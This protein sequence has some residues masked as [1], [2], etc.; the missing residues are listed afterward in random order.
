MRSVDGGHAVGSTGGNGFVQKVYAARITVNVLRVDDDTVF[1]DVQN[2][3]EV[4]CRQNFSIGARANTDNG[5]VGDLAALIGDQRQT[6]TDIAKD[7]IGQCFQ[8]LFQ[9]RIDVVVVIY[10]RINDRRIILKRYT[11]NGEAGQRKRVRF[12]FRQRL[13]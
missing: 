9:I 4:P 6:D 3:T 11:G 7:Q 2:I 13:R 12:V 5:T 1:G 10:S 8:I